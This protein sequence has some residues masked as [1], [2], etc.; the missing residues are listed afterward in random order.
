MG[1]ENVEKKPPKPLWDDYFDDV[2]GIELD[3]LL[4]YCVSLEA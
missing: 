3:V 2:H 4:Y 1:S